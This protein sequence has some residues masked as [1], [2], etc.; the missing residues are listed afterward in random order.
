MCCVSLREVPCPLDRYSSFRKAPCFPGRH[1]RSFMGFV[2]PRLLV[3]PGGG[4]GS[5]LV[6][7]PCT[8]HRPC[9]VSC[10]SIAPCP[11]AG[12]RDFPGVI[13]L[14]VGC[15]VPLTIPCLSMRLYYRSGGMHPAVGCYLPSI[16]PCSPARLHTLS[17]DMHHAPC[18]TP[19]QYQIFLD[20]SLLFRGVPCPSE[21]PFVGC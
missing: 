6:R 12:L 5:L 14:S 4:G 21:Y 16:V 2:S 10:F 20:C 7:A 18:S 19:V 13:C 3:T 8:M 9:E 17:C 1:V 15:H 11:S